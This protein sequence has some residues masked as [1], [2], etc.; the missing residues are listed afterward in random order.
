[1]KTIA[2]G[3]TG[4]LQRRPRTAVAALAATLPLTWSAIA[5]AN[6]PV[7]PPTP[8]DITVNSAADGLIL[9][10]AEL[11]LREAIS[12]ANGTLPVTAL[13]TAEQA[14]VVPSTT[15]A[16]SIAFALPLDT[17]IELVDELPPLA[18]PGLTVDGTT[19]PGYGEPSTVSMIT[20]VPQPIVGLKP[21][22]GTE[23]F[24][25]LTITAD[26]VTV[27]GLGFQGFSATHRSTQTTPP[28]DIFITHLAAPKDADNDIFAWDQLGF[29]NETEAPQ[30]VVIED[31]W[32]GLVGNDVMPDA[33]DMSA[34]GVFVFNGIDTVVQRNLIKYHEGS[35]IITGARAK[36]LVVTENTLVA[37]GLAGM[38]DSIRLDGDIDGAEIY[39]NLMCGSD[40][41]GIFMFKPTGSARIYNN[42]IRFN[43][44]RMRRSAIFLMGSGHEV[45]DNFI[46]YQPSP[47]VTVAAFPQSEKNIIRNNQF[48][49]LGGLSIDLGYNHNAVAQDFQRAD[50]PNP[51]RNSHNRRSDTGNAAINAPEFDA[52]TFPLTDGQSTLTGTAD[53]GSEVDVFVVI[54]PIGA[55]GGLNEYVT[56]VP[57]ADDGTFSVTVSGEEETVY[58][59]IATDAR[60][61][62][63]EP[64]AIAALGRLPEKK[65]FAYEATC[66][67]AQV[68]EP[69]PPAPELPPEPLILEVPRRIHF[70]LDQSNITPASAAIMDEIVAVLEEYPFIVVELEGHTDPRASNAYNQAL[71]ERRA[72][73]AR[74]YL[75]R[76]GIAPERMRIRSFGETQRTSDGSDRIDYARDRR[77]EFIFLDTRGL[78]IIYEDTETDLQIEP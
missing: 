50:G 23:V 51:P 46:G 48:V 2:P 7:A 8:Y 18:A 20:P 73:S 27:R 1:M 56:T 5:T 11:T 75:L 41:S 65:P 67:V 34:F 66:E 42:D 78:E 6:T 76:Q 60:Y 71:G 47:G 22:E 30:N 77:V 26:D 14:L 61:G 39:G 35:S 58:S 25:G 40:G 15:G 3:L 12:V 33:D 44:R 19:Q 55:Y 28:A 64:S 53:P 31:N 13:S 21:A 9:P 38:P 10:D 72:V 49:G 63:S 52:Y 29:T 59:A 68:P 36:G 17:T 62:T 32:L 43:G 37:N 70:A 4:F 16:P 74:D 24:R 45:F 54:D 69:E 57:V